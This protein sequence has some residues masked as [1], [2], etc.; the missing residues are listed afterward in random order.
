MLVSP[1][2]DLRLTKRL[3]AIFLGLHEAVAAAFFARGGQGGYFGWLVTAAKMWARATV[4][5]CLLMRVNL[6]A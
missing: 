1:I 4:D 6:L 3:N 2:S 5:T